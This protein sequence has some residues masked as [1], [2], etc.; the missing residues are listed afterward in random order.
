MNVL[1]REN[2]NLVTNEF[3]TNTK[4]K[5][6]IV[7]EEKSGLFLAHK[8]TDS[9]GMNTTEKLDKLDIEKKKPPILAKVI[10]QR[11]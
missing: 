6:T 7:N 8:A 11:N 1:K 3:V 2:S 9:A 10:L 4:I 5:T